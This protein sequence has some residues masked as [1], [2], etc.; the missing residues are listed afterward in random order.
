M[1]EGIDRRSAQKQRHRAAILAAAGA[2]IAERNGP[3]FS[4]DELAQRADVA[5]RTVFNHFSSSS[6]VVLA[7]AE[8]AIAERV[9][10]VT[11]QSRSHAAGGDALVAMFDDLAAILRASDLA[12]AITSIEPMLRGLDDL[13]TRS[14]IEDSFRRIAEGLRDELLRTH[15]LAD[16]LETDLLIG[17]LI[18]GVNVIARRWVAHDPAAPEQVRREK[19]D[20]LLTTCID[21][22]RW[23]YRASLPASA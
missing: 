6:G 1:D 11:A 14:F 12:S 2:L 4:V 19:W 9:Q 20:A 13:R 23:G 10:G 16:P 21:Q 5:R 18:S 22:A 8:A 7:L 3:H 15:P 17:S